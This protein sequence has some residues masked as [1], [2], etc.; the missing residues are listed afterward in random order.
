MK[1]DIKNINLAS[2]GNKRILWADKDMPVLAQIR[3]GFSKKKP[4]KGV[5]LAACLH[6]TAETANL[7]RTLKTGGAEV[8]LCASNPL[9][10]QDDVAASLVKDY[11]VSV[12]AINSE[13]RKTYYEHINRAIDLMP[14]ITM[15]DGADLVSLFH[16]KRTKG[17]S[18]IIGGTEETTTG[19]IRLKALALAGKLRYPIIAVN[20]AMTKHFFDNRY[21]T[22]QSTLDGIIRLTDILLAGS[23]VVIAGYG[24]CGRGTALKARG[25]GANVIVT[26]VDEIK[27]LEAVMDGFQ[28]MPMATAAPQG[29]L[30]ITLTGDINVIDKKHF[31]KMKS[32]AIICNSGHFDVEINIAGLKKMA[33]ARKTV[34]RLVDEYTLVGNKKIYVLAEGR[35]VNLAG[36]EGHPASVMDM[37]FAN[38]ALSSEYIM[39]YYRKLENRV[40]TI[41]EK[42][43]RNIARLKL[44]SINIAIDKLTKE[45]EKYLS[46]WEIGT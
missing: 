27:S 22:G 7:M 32:G 19:V 20:N 12:F 14:N 8:V 26:E 24:W 4:L 25:M 43:D 37:S 36:A 2:A 35:L 3:A 46:S 21:G 34:K 17:I 44:K 11:G 39:K 29:D 45:Q 1:S 33:H 42:I 9:S 41:P 28:V 16:S 13:S 31:L 40:Y 5:K 10:T 30:F 18:R 6:V 38:Q 15:D 23:T